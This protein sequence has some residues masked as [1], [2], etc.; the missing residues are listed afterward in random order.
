MANGRIAPTP[1]ALEEFLQE[2]FGDRVDDPVSIANELQAAAE[3]VAHFGDDDT[4]GCVMLTMGDHLRVLAARVRLLVRR[5]A[6]D[7]AVA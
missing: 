6:A 7:G 1:A 5:T 2:A 4:P 3:T